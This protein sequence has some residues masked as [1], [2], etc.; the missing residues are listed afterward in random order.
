[1]QIVIA[2]NDN[3]DKAM[4]EF[5]EKLKAIS[6]TDEQKIFGKKIFSLVVLKLLHIKK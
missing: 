5:C 2:T 4:A 3:V 6:L 1:M